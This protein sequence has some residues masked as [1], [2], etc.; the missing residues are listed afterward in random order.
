MSFEAQLGF[1][2]S[3]KPESCPLFVVISLRPRTGTQPP[4]AAFPR[5][6]AVRG[7]AVPGDGGRGALTFPAPW[8]RG[9]AGAGT[10]RMFTD[11]THGQ[12]HGRLDGPTDD[13]LA[14]PRQ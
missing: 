14:E 11:S 5:D 12:I 4:K 8:R 7:S 10:W 13:C 3:G 1:P 9:R 6:R 2:V